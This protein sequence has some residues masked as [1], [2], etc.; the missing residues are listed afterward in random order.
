VPKQLTRLVDQLT[1]R[2]A[3]L[4]PSQNPVHSDGLGRGVSGMWKTPQC[5]DSGGPF[6]RATAPMGL[7]PDH[8]PHGRSPPQKSLGLKPQH[9]RTNPLT[10]GNQKATMR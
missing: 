7:P 1:I 4:R 10:K 6:I 3:R 5:A 2:G 9:E 8:R